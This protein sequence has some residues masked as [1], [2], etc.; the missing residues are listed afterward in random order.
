MENWKA[1]HH[2]IA[3][4]IQ[5]GRQQLTREVLA[6]GTLRL[7]AVA[8]AGF[9]VGT[10][11]HLLLPL[12]SAPALG[13]SMAALAAV[14]YALWRVLLRPY[15]S[16]PNPEQFVE[17][18]DARHDQNKN[19]IV[20]AWQLGKSQAGTAIF[21]PDLVEA[22]VERGARAAAGVN[23][24]GWRNRKNDRNWW[25]SLAGASALAALLLFMAGPE[26]FG[27]AARKLIDP[28]LAALAPVTITVQPGDRT[29]ERGADV[30]LD[31]VVTGTT[32]PPVLRVRETGGIWMSRRLNVPAGVPEVAGGAVA[33]RTALS[34]V[35]RDQEYQVMVHKTETPVW[36]I[37]VNEAPRVAGFEITYYYP[38]YTGKEPE[39]MTSGSGDLAALTG[40]RVLLK[41]LA[42]R[43]MG[44][45][46]MTKG[47]AGSVVLTGVTPL[48]AVDAPN[49]ETRLTMVGEPQEYTINLRDAAG[50]DKF[51]SPRFR[52]ESAP[53]RPPV[54]RLVS[55]SEDLPIPE[56][57][58]LMLSAEAVDDFGLS[59]LDLIWSVKDGSDGRLRLR[60]FSAGTAE[61]HADF[62]WDLVPLN[63]VPGS[64]VSYFLEVFDNDRVSGPKSA[65]SEVRRLR[66]PTMEEIYAEV[67]DEH[68]QQI[69]DLSST[70]QQG[71]EL[72]EQLE[73]L[74]RESKRGDEL[75][76]D[77]KKEMENLLEKQAQLEKQL[78][79]TAR[80]LQETLK[81]AQEETFLSPELLQKMQE[82]SEL[83]SSIQNEKLKESFEK[84]NEALKNMDQ[85]AINKALENF[86]LDQEEMVKGL[87]KT[88]E[89]LKEIRKEEML[90]DSVRKAEELAREQEKLA[91][92]IEKE[93]EKD[94]KGQDKDGKDPAAEKKEN[95]D[96]ADRQ[97]EAKKKAEDLAKQL[98]ELSKLAENEKKLQEELDQAKQ[99][100]KQEDMKQKM[101]KSEESLRQGEKEKALDFAFKAAEDAKQMAQEMKKAQ[102]NS[103]AAKK[104]EMQ[105]KMMAVIQDLVD[106]SSA[107]EELLAQAPG[108]A[109]TEMAGRQRVLMDGVL[110]S[111]LELE[112]L[113]K[114]TLFVNDEQKT[115]IGSAMKRMKSATEAYSGGNMGG[116]MREGKESAGDL[117]EAIVEL[118]ESHSSMC[119]SGSSTGFQE[120]M[121][122]MAGLS[123]QQQDLNDQAQ[124]MANGKGSQPR[125]SREG[126]GARQM[127][128]MAARQEMIKRGLNEVAG[129]M[130][131]RKDMLGRLDQLGKEMGDV[132]DEMRKNGVSDKLLE[133]QEK[134]LNR[135]LDAQKSVRRKDE[136][137]ER[138]SKTAEQLTRPSP[139]PLTG[140]QLGGSERLRSDILRGQ[141]DQFPAQFRALVEKYFRALSDKKSAAPEPGR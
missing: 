92:D 100:P 71:K 60:D 11:L 77:R 72:Q 120:Q 97:E 25:I 137:E 87:D 136:R 68:E 135:L 110:K 91:G 121:Q 124:S 24:S 80:Q 63:L 127:E 86:K 101:E 108:T 32:E 139:G 85:E 58:S 8:L 128:D 14:G 19:I 78:E 112:A 33:Y 30:A 54:I 95:E 4:R 3:R 140:D 105:E 2:D 102:Q 34:R 59:R 39:N 122:K 138:E 73:K 36:K 15:R 40:T 57:M 42:N 104:R 6:A 45:A 96:L 29:I 109:E 118:M 103:N 9:V 13:L 129:K 125:L 27:G 99:S 64:E 10:A 28:R 126:S 131:E 83:M 93:S 50:V 130:G 70:L 47:P 123:E 17:W 81:K 23:L 119:N 20:S 37:V 12:G 107:Q 5:D 94:Q 79:Q 53:D 111:A 116:A 51:T 117:N 65:R 141:S 74:A 31:I 75:S 52:I 43:P 61:L 26:R 55:P 115:M 69:D 90:E 106:V 62:N 84:L 89:M 132:A 46:V 114:R 113:G 18:L 88:I 98:D 134:I 35:E 133:R 67:Q 21:A 38:E 82:I 76:W 56:E 41:V 66:F 16:R 1:A 48:D 44:S 7:L 22:V 49:W